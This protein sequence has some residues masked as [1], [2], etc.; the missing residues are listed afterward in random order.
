[1][2]EQPTLGQRI[3]AGYTGLRKGLASGGLVAGPSIPSTWPINWFQQGYT[4][5]S[6]ATGGATV[7]ACVSTTARTIASLPWYHVRDLP[8]GSREILNR[9]GPSVVMRRPNPYQTASDFKLNLVRQLLFD[10]NAYWFGDGSTQRDHENIYLLD[11]RSTMPR[12]LRSDSDVELFYATGGEAANLASI[13]GSVMIPQRYVGHA[14]LATGADPLLGVSPIQ[15]AAQSVMANNAIA[16]HFAGFTTNMSRPSGVLST[17][18][19]LTKDQMNQLREAWE[20]QAKGLNSGGVP[21]LANGLKWE[22]I[23]L[24]AV[25]AELIGAWKATN[26]D[27]ARVFGIPPQIIGNA[28]NSTFNNVSVLMGFWLSTGLGFFISHVENSMNR[29]FG[30][31]RTGESH[32]WFDTDVLMRTDFAGMV[33]ALGDSVT[34][35]IHAPNEARRQFGLEAVE[36]GD[37]PRVQQQMVPLDWEAPEASEPPPAQETPEVT[38]DEID[39]LLGDDAA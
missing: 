8:D 27:I 39:T 5:P 6:N 31:D 4:A 26:D 35:G 7:E 32:I 11:S 25:D 18:L 37:M 22:Q 20:E 16:S 21:I 30:L 1:M 2:S 15:S 33:K 28:E 36:G 23:S 10:G 29:F 19:N 38:D 13:E 3:K 14:R 17:E 9:S 12:L 24:S 34:K